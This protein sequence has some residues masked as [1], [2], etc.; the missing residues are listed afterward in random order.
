MLFVVYN[1][2]SGMIRH[3]SH[4]QL[5]Y[6]MTTHLTIATSN[7]ISYITMF[8]EK[9][10]QNVLRLKNAEKLITR[11]RTDLANREQFIHVE[12]SYTTNN[13]SS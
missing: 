3:P 1:L 12:Q 2:E 5:S 9:I 11:A 10:L 8:T 7:N 4:A 6:C 13:S